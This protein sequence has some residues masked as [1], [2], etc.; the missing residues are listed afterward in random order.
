[1]GQ[2]RRPDDLEWS[3][4]EDD[5]A[6][7]LYEH[8]SSPLLFATI[9]GDLVLHD[10]ESTGVFES[11]RARGYR[12]FGVRRR[13][14]VKFEDRFVLRASHPDSPSELILF[15]IRTHFAEVDWG[16]QKIRALSWD[17]LEFQDP[18]G[19]FD[20][21]KPP[22]PGQERPG[23]GMF[24]T[25]TDLLKRY[26]DRTDAEAILT[27]PEYFH[28]AYLYSRGFTFRQAEV[29]GRFQ[30][31]VRDLMPLGLAAASRALAELKVRDGHGVV[32]AWEPQLQVCPLSDRVRSHFHTDEYRR[33]LD[34]FKGSSSYH[35]ASPTG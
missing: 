32:V 8:E 33:T 35:V 31:L 25:I 27:V 28:N 10:L 20:P 19:Q 1:M 23:L 3:L 2:K 22:L 21:A 34:A 9:E 15:D 14:G 24:R 11:L 16:G 13:S 6:P 29:E 17:W 4:S 18:M 12:D 26:V 5:F 30:A 7:T